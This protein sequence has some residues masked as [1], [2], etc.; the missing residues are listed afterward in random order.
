MNLQNIDIT[1][2][3]SGLTSVKPISIEPLD[4]LLVKDSLAT[5][6]SKIGDDVQIG[7]ESA[8][9]ALGNTIH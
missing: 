8:R 6:F 7:I 2:E 4:G 5:E 1:K 3:L 9:T